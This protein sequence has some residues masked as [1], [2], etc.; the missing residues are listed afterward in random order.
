MWIMGVAALLFNPLIPFHLSRG[1]WS[2]LDAAAALLFVLA[3]F[4]IRSPV[5]AT[6]KHVRAR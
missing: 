3:L 5:S 2:F 1:I 6:P 4:L